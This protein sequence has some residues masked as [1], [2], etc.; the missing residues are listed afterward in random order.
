M[1]VCN[2]LLD[3]IVYGREKCDTRRV[4]NYCRCIATDVVYSPTVSAYDVVYTEDV[5][6]TNVVESNKE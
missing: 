6:V 1:N 3:G 4:N 2:K 5:D